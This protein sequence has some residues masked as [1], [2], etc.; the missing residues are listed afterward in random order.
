MKTNGAWR[1]SII[2]PLINSFEWQ[3]SKLH[4]CHHQNVNKTY[5]YCEGLKVCEY[6]EANNSTTAISVKRRRAS[7]EVLYTNW[8]H[9]FVTSKIKHHQNRTHG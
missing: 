3:V 5:D 4:I 7:K 9:S 2:L 1:E 6:K 8:C